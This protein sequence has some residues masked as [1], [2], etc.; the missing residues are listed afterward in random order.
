MRQLRLFFMVLICLVTVVY[1]VE[2]HNKSVFLE[3]NWTN[4]SN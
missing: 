3:N 2:A 4:Y 1:S